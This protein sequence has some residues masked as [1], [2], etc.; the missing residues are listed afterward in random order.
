MTTRRNN[1]CKGDGTV[2]ADSVASARSA[3]LRYVRD[4]GPGIRRL[5][6]GAGFRYVGPDGRA[7]R[8]PAA[9]RRIRALAIPP[10]WTRVW[11]CPLAEGHL[12]AT[13]FDARGRKQYRYHPRW[14]AARDETKFDRMASFGRALPRIRARTEADLAQPG[15]PRTKVLAGVVRLLESTLIRIGNEEY[16]RANG[17]FGLTTL[18]NRHVRVA[19]A[20][21]RFRFRGKSGIRRAVD[22]HDRRLARLVRRCQ[23]LPGDEMFQ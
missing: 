23:D 6:C 13:G 7:L 8:D 17:S 19:G 5:R 15:L 14:R 20:A 11:V 18:R 2:V 4:D 16:A 21:L 12:Q 9:L 10:A 1:G 3:G 22:L